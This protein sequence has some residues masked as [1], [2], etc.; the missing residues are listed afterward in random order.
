M[1]PDTH[2]NFEEFLRV[3]DPEQ[4]YYIEELKGGVINA[5]VRATKKEPLRKSRFSSYDSLILKHAKPY[6]LAYGPSFPMNMARQVSG[7]VY[8]KGDCI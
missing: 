2:F 6:I 3:L 1:T 7:R 5:I 4:A 8:Y